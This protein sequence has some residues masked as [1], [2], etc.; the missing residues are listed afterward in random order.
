MNNPL[1]ICFMRSINAFLLCNKYMQR[2][3]MLLTALTVCNTTNIHFSGSYMEMP[4]IVHNVS[5]SFGHGNFDSKC[6][7][8][9]LK[10]KT[11]K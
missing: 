3:I 4:Q 7:S 6:Q 5:G 10:I 1:F 11:I 2:S 8:T 9:G